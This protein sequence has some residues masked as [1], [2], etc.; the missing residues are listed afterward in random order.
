MAGDAGRDRF[1]GLALPQRHDRV[2]DFGDHLANVI[3]MASDRPRSESAGDQAALR[4]MIG[5]VQVDHGLI[6]GQVDV[7]SRTTE[8]GIANAIPLDTP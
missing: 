5:I 1:N 2:E 3:L 6:R 8:G 7:W 4:L